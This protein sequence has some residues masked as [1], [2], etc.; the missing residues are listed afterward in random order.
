LQAVSIPEQVAY[1]DD[2]PPQ[3]TQALLTFLSFIKAR[4][5]LN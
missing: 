3:G 5:R 2:L 4:N 1:T